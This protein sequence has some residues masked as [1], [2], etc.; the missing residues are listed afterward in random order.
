[1]PIKHTERVDAETI[2]ITRW[3]DAK[4]SRVFAAW[5]R[6]EHLTRWFGPEG[7]RCETESF[8]LRAGGAWI[9]QMRHAEHGDRAGRMVGDRCQDS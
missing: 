9:F 5:T 8:D 3:L 6:L 4:P 7:F 1:M 2:E